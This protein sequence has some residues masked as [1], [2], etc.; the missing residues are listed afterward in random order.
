MKICVFLSHEQFFNDVAEEL[1]LFFPSAKILTPDAS[2]TLATAETGQGGPEIAALR[3]KVENNV[4]SAEFRASN[5]RMRAFLPCHAYDDAILQKRHLRRAYKLAVYRALK[6]EYGRPSPWGSLTGIRPTKFAR[7]LLEELSAADEVSSNFSALRGALLNEFDLR[8]DKVA[9]LS[10]VLETQKNLVAAGG[11]GNPPLQEYIDVYIGIPFCATRCSYCSFAAEALKDYNRVQAYLTALF[12]EMD[13]CGELLKSNSVRALYI[14]GGTPTSLAP[15]E[16]E[17]LLEKAA[18]L[19]PALEFAVEAGRPDT[20]TREKLALMKRYG[21]TRTSVNPQTMS[22]ATLARIGRAHTAADT[23]KAFELTRESG[24]PVN[25][26]IIVGL[27][28]ETR[29]EVAHTLETLETLAPEGFTAHTLALKRASRLVMSG[30]SALPG[31]EE[32]EVMLAMTQ[33]FARKCG[34]NPYYLYR[35][36][37]MAGNL[38]NVGYAKPGFECLYNIDI[39]EE[40]TS[41]LAFGAGAITKW[42]FGGGRL[43][44]SPNP[45]DVDTYIMKAEELA[46]RKLELAFTQPSNI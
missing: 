8:E 27:P 25:A 45:K 32:A 36:K 10:H 15:R 24:I 31:A 35:Q 29:R 4:V 40:T 43:E 6:S 20:L 28:G 7:G 41:I 30:E 18:E 5:M 23:I 12:Q 34:M 17:R 16:F 22:D 46:K 26:D 3:V 37:Y 11:H 33:E 21:V 2:K 39:M 13:A 1:R 38:E 42:I 14:G 19:A 9:L 44:R